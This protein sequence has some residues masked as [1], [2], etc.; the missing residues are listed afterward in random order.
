[1][2]P[3]A[4][5]ESAASAPTSSPPSEAWAGDRGCLASAPARGG[6]NMRTEAADLIIR[7]IQR[8]DPSYQLIEMRL[9][10]DRQ[11]A[12]GSA[13]GAGLQDDQQF[14]RVPRLAAGPHTLSIAYWLRGKGTGFYGYMSGY[15]F[16]VLSSHSF[17]LAPGQTTC[18]STLLYFDPDL[19]LPPGE[20]PRVDFREEP[21][22]AP[23][24]PLGQGGK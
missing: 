13:E 18:I 3:P 11:Q 2:T 12:Y 15:K 6:D 8:S 10:V 1:M 19:A 21:S 7:T 17:T 24:E 23:N 4:H 14:V 16:K 5:P 20:R 9:A 22:P